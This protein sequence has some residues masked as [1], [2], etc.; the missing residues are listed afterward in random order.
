VDTAAL[1]WCAICERKKDW[2]ILLTFHHVTCFA[3]IASCLHLGV[4]AQT[5]AIATVMG[6]ITNPLHNLWWMSKDVPGLG[7]LYATLSPIFTYVYCF[8]R[9]VV[10]PTVSADV[11]YFLIGVPNAFGQTVGVAFAS[12][13]ILVNV[14]GMKWSIGLWSG[15]QKF[16]SK[17]NSDGKS[18]SA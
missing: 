9:C 4:G 5:A 3:Y 6:E 14:G 2:P 18:K 17:E 8:I 16:L 10:A 12:L 11:V 1:W 7:D 15:Y 13:C